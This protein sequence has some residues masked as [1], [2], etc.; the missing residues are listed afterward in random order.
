MSKTNPTGVRF[1][2]EI[3]K[4]LKQEYGE[5]SYQAALRIYE[6]I[7]QRTKR[8]PTFLKADGDIDKNKFAKKKKK[9]LL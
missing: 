6:E 4:E 2:P 5:I 7:Y 9:R 3:L 1:N 8:V